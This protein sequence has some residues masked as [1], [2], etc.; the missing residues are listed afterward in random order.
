MRT[1]SSTPGPTKLRGSAVIDTEGR[2]KIACINWGHDDAPHALVY[3]LVDG[4]ARAER[5]F[6]AWADAIK[7]AFKEA[8]DR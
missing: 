6:P 5:Y 7:A 3:L 4:E 2:W 1:R 8:P